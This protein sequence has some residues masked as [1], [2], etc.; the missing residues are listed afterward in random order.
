M[1]YGSKSA[2]SEAGAGVVIFSNPSS[3]STTVSYGHSGYGASPS[4]S[5]PTVVTVVTVPPAETPDVVAATN[6]VYGYL[7]AIR[8]LN[9]TNV[10]IP[11]ISTA[12]SIPHADVITALQKLKERGVKYKS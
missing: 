3:S 7:Q 8:A 2:A 12:L 4:N 1:T 5:S 9:R 11:E 6:A 10:S